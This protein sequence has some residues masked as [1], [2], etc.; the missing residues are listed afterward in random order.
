LLYEDG[1]I[2]CLRIVVEDGEGT[3]VND[4][5]LTV[6]LSAFIEMVVG[7]GTIAPLE[8]LSFAGLG[9]LLIGVVVGDG[10]IVP[11]ESLSFA[12]LGTLLIEVVVGDGTIV[13][14]S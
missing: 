7:D 2:C 10:T 1:D 14:E 8:S 9:T 13:V 6:G 12:G 11:L 3:I 4:D 5:G